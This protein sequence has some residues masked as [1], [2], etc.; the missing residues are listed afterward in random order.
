[1]PEC[2]CDSCKYQE[3]NL[4]LIYPKCPNP[5]EYNMAFM[6]EFMYGR[7]YVTCDKYVKKEDTN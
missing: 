3:L 4:N 5:K 1:M 6:H 7:T 2:V